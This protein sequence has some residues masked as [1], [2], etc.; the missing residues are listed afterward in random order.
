MGSSSLRHLSSSLSN[1]LDVTFLPGRMPKDEFISGITWVKSKT[2]LIQLA[3]KKSLTRFKVKDCETFL[4]EH[5]R[6][7]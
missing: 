5:S 7:F 2:L 4:L 6:T 3:G 1:I